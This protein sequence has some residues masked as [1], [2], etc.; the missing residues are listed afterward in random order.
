M[1]RTA[2]HC[3]EEGEEVHLVSGDTSMFLTR[4]SYELEIK[5]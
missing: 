2:G 1:V 5:R 4:G 3:Q